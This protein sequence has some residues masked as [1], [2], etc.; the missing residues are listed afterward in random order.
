MAPPCRSKARSAKTSALS[1][2]GRD[3]EVTDLRVGTNG[4]D[5]SS[6]SRFVDFGQIRREEAQYPRFLR[7]S[8][9]AGS[10]GAVCFLGSGAGG[11][12]KGAAG[13]LAAGAA[14][15][16]AGSGAELPLPAPGAAM[17]VDS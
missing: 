5:P 3:I 14:G 17:G 2:S 8:S 4:A 10:F 16:A 13:A 12:G 6:V 11:V 1:R 7:N 15:R 9:R